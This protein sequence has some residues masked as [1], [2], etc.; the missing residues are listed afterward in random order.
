MR[1]TT[2]GGACAKAR[3]V[4]GDMGGASDHEHEH[5]HGEGD[6]HS[7]TAVQVSLVAVSSY[8][9]YMLSEALELSGTLTM[10]VCAL[11][12]AH[13]RSG[14]TPRRMLH[15]ALCCSCAK[16]CST[17]AHKTWHQL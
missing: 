1:A 14:A 5:E 13:V 2:V 6:R 15:S 9:S 3:A 8:L 7:V 16:C 17:R 12:L 10:F 11:V 4:G